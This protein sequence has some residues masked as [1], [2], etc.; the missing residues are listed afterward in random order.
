MKGGCF[1]GAVRYEVNRK[2]SEAYLN[3]FLVHD[4][5]FT[6]E[7]LNNQVYPYWTY[8]QLIFLALVPTQLHARLLPLLLVVP[9]I[10][11]DSILSSMVRAVWF[12]FYLSYLV[13]RPPK[14]SK[15]FLA[16]CAAL[17]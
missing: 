8:G 7:E 14:C 3:P 6:N 11:F 12:I 1:C 17:E 10:R 2:P 5:G 13:R 4:K 15:L 9:C 16:V